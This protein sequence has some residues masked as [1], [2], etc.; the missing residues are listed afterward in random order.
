MEKRLKEAKDQLFESDRSR[1]IL[2]NEIQD[3]K[4]KVRVVARVRPSNTRNDQDGDKC[5][6]EDL[7]LVCGAD[8]MELQVETVQEQSTGSTTRQNKFK[9]DR[10]FAPNTKQY[11]VFGEVQSFVQSALD[12]YNVCLF[13]YGQT[14]SG[15]TYT[16]TGD[17]TSDVHRGIIP[18]AISNIMSHQKELRDK[19]WLFS[20]QASFVEIYNESIRDLL[21]STPTKLEVRDS[22]SEINV[23][24]VIKLDVKD[25]E[26][27][28]NILSIAAKNRSVAATDL[29]LESSRSHSV[30]T[31][32]ISGM[33]DQY[34]AQ[35]AG[36]L[37]MC[38]L[39]G[40]ERISRSNVSGDRLK[41]T[42][43]INKSLSSLAD[44]FAS[45]S[46]KTAHVP[47]RNSKLTHMLQPCFAGQG[48]TMMIL[49]LSS[50]SDDVAETM[51]SLRFGS[52]VNKTEL[53]K[54]KKQISNV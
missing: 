26:D 17:H 43:A 53:G 40:S 30:F 3:L 46:K 37:S 48:K 20:F 49:N 38:D 52:Q 16:M 14:G 44:V 29:N 6:D 28:D 27:V 50:D 18:R 47:Y 31:L 41:E 35:L 5:M 51:C 32:F 42:Q 11:E 12:G 54:A 7:T 1:R 9:F 21:T 39:A 4:G 22:K 8:G 2:H 45:L 19:G 10:V 25:Q 13:S 24:G 36:S 33:N 34:K 23:P 15:K